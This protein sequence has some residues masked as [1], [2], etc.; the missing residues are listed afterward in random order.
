[1]DLGV[2]SG[3]GF[4][5]RGLFSSHDYHEATNISFNHMASFSP[6]HTGRSRCGIGVTMARHHSAF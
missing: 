2:T 6:F 3:P 5:R 1:M 4:Y